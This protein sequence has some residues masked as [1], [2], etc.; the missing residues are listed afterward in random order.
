MEKSWKSMACI[1]V[2]IIIWPSNVSQHFDILSTAVGRYTSNAVEISSVMQSLPG[3]FV[4]RHICIPLDAGR[5]KWFS[6]LPISTT[7][8]ALTIDS[9]RPASKV[10][11]KFCWT[12]AKLILGTTE[13]EVKSGSTQSPRSWPAHFNSSLQ[14]Y[15]HYVMDKHCLA[16]EIDV[17]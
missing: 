5:K 11:S 6:S 14:M 12:S 2:I 10:R 3:T 17:T 7:G 8:W 13:R 1:D 9:S 15:S 4:G 16:T